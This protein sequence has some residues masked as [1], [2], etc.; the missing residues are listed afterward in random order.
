MNGGI[1]NLFMLLLTINVST[2][3]DMSIKNFVHF[4][5]SS[6][7]SYYWVYWVQVPLAYIFW[8]FDWI[9]D[10]SFLNSFLR[11]SFKE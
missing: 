10:F 3:G 7:I 11:M 4:Y 6:K 9:F 2:F 5:L 1:E 8:I